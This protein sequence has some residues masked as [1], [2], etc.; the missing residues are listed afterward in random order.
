MRGGGLYTVPY[1]IEIIVARTVFASIVT[2]FTL[3][4]ICVL[5][6][7]DGFSFYSLKLSLTDKLL[8]PMLSLLEK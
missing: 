3:L 8:F 4:F 7:Y 1:T 5:I 6:R 2:G